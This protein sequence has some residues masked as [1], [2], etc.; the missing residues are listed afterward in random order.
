[1]DQEVLSKVHLLQLK[2]A[3][4]I[5]RICD[6]NNID[7]ILDSGTLL[8]AVRHKGFIPW[9]DD[10][11][12][13]MTSE[14]Y[15]KFIEACKTDLGEEFFLQTWE[16]DKNYPLAYAKIKLNGT[17]YVESYF[18]NRNMDMHLGIFVDVLPY[19]VWPAKKRLQKKLWRRRAFLRAMIMMKCRYLRFKSSSFKKYILKLG[20]FTVIKFLTLFCSKQSLIDKYNRMTEKYNKC[21]SDEMYEHTA[22]IKFGYWVVSKTCFEKFIDL[23]FEDDT[24]KCPANYDEYLTKVY[25]D[26]MT[27][28]PEEVRWKGHDV[29]EVDLGKYQNITEETV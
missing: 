24:F 11:D 7:Y 21:E 26:Y 23:P 29:I 20:M 1:M 5:K 17:K 28:P 2:I 3:K 19:S 9:D 14:N 13:A 10:M 6:K 16:T 22:N 27:P 25:G 8:G 15:K 12:M 18:E 4:E